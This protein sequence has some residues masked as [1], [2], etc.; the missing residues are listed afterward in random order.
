M[1]GLALLRVV[2]IWAWALAAILAWGGWQRH[3][4][5]QAQTALRLHDA[6][7]AAE[8]IKAQQASMTETARRLAAAKEISDDAQARS[9][10]AA[11]DAAGARSAADGLRGQLAAIAASAAAGNPP[12]ADARQAG[13]LAESLGQCVSRYADVASAADDAINRG[14]ACERSYDS[15]SKP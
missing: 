4:A 6:A 9:R 1:P 11:L 8:T 14:R 7:I 10:R 15:L 13:A 2:P 12:A 5:T 3:A